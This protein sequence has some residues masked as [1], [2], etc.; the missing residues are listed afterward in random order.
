MMNLFTKA[1]EEKID[2]RLPEKTKA[3]FLTTPQ[4]SIEVNDTRVGLVQEFALTEFRGNEY[5]SL[6]MNRLVTDKPFIEEFLSARF[7][8]GIEPFDVRI[9]ENYDD[10]I[11]IF[12]LK[13]CTIER[14]S[15]IY[16][17]ESFL[18]SEDFTIKSNIYYKRIEASV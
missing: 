18:V 13:E 7:I 15:K 11:V 8:E 16:N 10:Y 9:Q 5:I 17:A 2:L 12:T 6:D 3:G 4:V 1:E 14:V